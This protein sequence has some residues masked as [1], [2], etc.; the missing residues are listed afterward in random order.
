[1]TFKDWVHQSH[2]LNVMLDQVHNP[3]EWVNTLE[4]CWKAAQSEALKPVDLSS[5]YIIDDDCGVRGR[6]TQHKGT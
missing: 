5:S 4:A 3:G 6:E 1:M 2:P